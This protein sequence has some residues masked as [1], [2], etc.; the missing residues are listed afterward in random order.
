[1]N[2]GFPKIV[3]VR[4]RLYFADL[5]VIM[6]WHSPA[7]VV[8]MGWVMRFIRRSCTL[9]G[10][11]ITLLIFLDIMAGYSLAAMTPKGGA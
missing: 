5:A 11:G 9:G 10:C 3:C 7:A 4:L 2:A 6:Q 8:R 1:M